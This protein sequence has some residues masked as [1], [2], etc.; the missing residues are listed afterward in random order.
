MTTI[1][2]AVKKATVA[3]AVLHEQDPP[4]PSREQP[5][6]IVGS[7][8]C[9]HP[10]GV[11]LTCAHVIEA[12]MEKTIKEQ[13]E[14]IPPEERKNTGPHKI[15]DVKTL[16]P[17]ALF[18]LPRPDRHEVVVVCAR[19]DMGVAKTDK[20]VAAVRLHHYAAFSSGYPIVDIEDFDSLHEGME[21]GTCGFPLG[22]LLFKQLGTVTSS[23]S[24]G[25]VSSILPAPGVSRKDLEGFQLD[26]RATH[27]NSGGPVISW[28]TGR[29]LGILQG[30][31]NDQYG[32]FLFSRAESIYRLL[33]ERFIEDVLAGHSVF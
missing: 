4:R 17:H 8:F 23:F 9:V 11:V 18:Y 31:I 27:G 30:G 33:D 32:T 24:R 28:S 15:P 10:K 1:F 12:F 13:I 16:V 22:N 21:V 26:L 19:V 6:T 5:F 14:S 7:G 2:D 20:D 3:L 25:I 29:V